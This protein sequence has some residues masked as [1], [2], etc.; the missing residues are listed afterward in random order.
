M[1]TK[2]ERSFRSRLRRRVAKVKKERELEA[3]MSVLG[4]PAGYTVSLMGLLF[5]RTTEHETIEIE[6]TEPGMKSVKSFGFESLRSLKKACLYFI[7]KRHSL[8]LGVD[9]EH[10]CATCFTPLDIS[11]SHPKNRAG[12]VFCDERC[13]SKAPQLSKRKA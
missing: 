6:Y 8:L 9:H 12:K 2:A 7:E 1:S 3:L 10:A 4:G 5:I 13:R 11:D